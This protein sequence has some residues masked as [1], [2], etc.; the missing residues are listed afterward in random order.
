MNFWDMTFDEIKAFVKEQGWPEY[1]A[2]QICERMYAGDADFSE[3]S[4]LPKPMREKLTEI[5]SVKLPEPLKVQTSKDGTV[6][7]LW[8]FADDNTA[9]SV[10]MRY[11]YGG[12]AC[13]S[14]QIGCRMNCAFCATGESG[15][16]RN[17]TSGEMM[18]QLMGLKRESG[19]EI[20]RAVLMGMGEPLDNLGEA[21]KFLH[22]VTGVGNMSARHISVSTCGIPDKIIELAKSKIPVTLS[23]SLHAPDDET[24]SRIMPINKKYGVNAVIKAAEEYFRITSRRVSYEYI[25]LDGINDS[26]EQAEMLTKKLKGGHVNIIEYNAVKGKPFKPSRNIKRFTEILGKSGLSV[27]VR[28]KLGHGINAACGQLKQSKDVKQ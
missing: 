9:E 3:M 5:A 14:T 22:N 27:T 4:A 25:M 8:K 7:V 11:K 18:G 10:L 24:R 23:V 16:V 1:R 17:L 28:R 20:S 15:L 12:S 13:L 26:A 21:I 2:K 19:C 6:K